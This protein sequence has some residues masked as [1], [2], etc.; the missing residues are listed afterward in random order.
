[1]QLLFQGE[2]VEIDS[3][4]LDGLSEALLHL[5]NNAVIHGIE[6]PT[7]R[8]AAGKTPKGT[9]TIRTQPQRGALVLEISDDGRGI[10]LGPSSKKLWKR[11]CAHR[12]R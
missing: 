9:L 10:D 4:L 3:V 12:P 5:I 11:A 7:E 8:L 1:M 2:Q 6:S